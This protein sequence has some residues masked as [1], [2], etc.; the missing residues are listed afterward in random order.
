VNSS[1]SAKI[2]KIKNNIIRIIIG[3]KSVES[4]RDLFKNLKILPLQSQYTISLILYVLQNK[5]KLKLNSDVCNMNA[6][7]KYNFHQPSLNL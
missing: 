2:I 4:Y 1:H 5:N 7:Q 6:K 3:C